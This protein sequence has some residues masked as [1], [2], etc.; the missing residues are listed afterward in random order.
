M[1][2][3]APVRAPAVMTIAA[4]AGDQP[5]CIV[6]LGV[7]VPQLSLIAFQ[8]PAVEGGALLLL[9]DL[10]GLDAAPRLALKCPAVSLGKRVPPHTARNACMV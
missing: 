4:E 6:S 7:V 9:L 5:T 3:G 8:L 10:R 2:R 1:V